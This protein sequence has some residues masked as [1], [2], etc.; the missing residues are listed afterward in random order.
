MPV[1]AGSCRFVLDRID[2]R[3]GKTGLNF[4]VLG[5]LWRGMAVPLFWAVL[6]NPGNSDINDL[7]SFRWALKILPCT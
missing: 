1:G 6:G 2:C 5:A 4:L 7:S 3:L